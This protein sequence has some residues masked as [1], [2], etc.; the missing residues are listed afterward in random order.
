MN[1]TDQGLLYIQY[2]SQWLVVSLYFTAVPPRPGL[3]NGQHNTALHLDVNTSLLRSSR[4]THGCSFIRSACIP[5]IMISLISIYIMSVFAYSNMNTHIHIYM[6]PIS[7]STRFAIIIPGYA[8]VSNDVCALTIIA[9]R[10]VNRWVI[11][12]LSEFYSSHVCRAQMRGQGLF[13]IRGRQQ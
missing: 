13:P 10:F 9:V 5:W 12:Q 1:H 7:F 3:I 6:F 4:T 8:I 2:V 11:T